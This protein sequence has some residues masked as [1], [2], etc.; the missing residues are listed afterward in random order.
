[1]G[2]VIVEVC[3]VNPASGLDLESLESAYPGTSV[4]RTSCLS[5]CSE[6]ALH[7]YA[8]VNGEIHWAETTDELWNTI[9]TAIAAELA[10]LG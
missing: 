3:D 7:P 4:I 6:C 2:I 9:K 5:N 1:M 10:A 8:Y